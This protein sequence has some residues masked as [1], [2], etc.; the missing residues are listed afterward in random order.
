MTDR[1]VTH[2]YDTEGNQ[3]FQEISDTED[4]L[5]HRL[6]HRATKKT[7]RWVS[8]AQAA[9]MV[10]VDGDKKT[11]EVGVSPVYSKDYAVLTAEEFFIN[12]YNY[13][14]ITLP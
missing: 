10:I 4:G 9:V 13:N 1:K 6:V 3:C 5:Y 8:Y 7:G 12:F 11:I 14:R 2:C